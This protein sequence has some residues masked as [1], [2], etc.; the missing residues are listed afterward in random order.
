MAKALVNNLAAEWDPGKYTDEYR[1]NLMRI[2][3]AKLKGKDVVLKPDIEP[4]QAGVVDL[5]ERLRR[6][7]ELSAPGRQRA[8]GKRAMKTRATGTAKK[9]SAKKRRAA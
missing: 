2:I 5:M 9:A 6:S 3:Q 8:A 7:L 1:E 4:R